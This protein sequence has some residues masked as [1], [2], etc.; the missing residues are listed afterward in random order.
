MEKQAKR[1]YTNGNKAAEKISNIR[2]DVEE[3]G[4]LL[5]LSDFTCKCTHT[6]H[7]HYTHKLHTHYTHTTHTKHTV[8]LH[9][10]YLHKY[11]LH[12]DYI[13]FSN[14]S[15]LVSSGKHPEPGQQVDAV[16]RKFSLNHNVWVKAYTKFS[17]TAHDDFV[18]EV[19]RLLEFEHK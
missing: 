15:S 14:S 11:T 6:L 10:V 8:Y 4:Q 19:K 17:H 13:I 3:K 7:T 2:K 16:C 1:G 5:S 9:T 18:E 12:T